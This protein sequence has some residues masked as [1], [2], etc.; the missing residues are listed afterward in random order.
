MTSSALS[1]LYKFLQPSLDT[2]VIPDSVTSNSGAATSSPFDTIKAQLGVER[3]V[4]M[5]TYDSVDRGKSIGTFGLGGCTAGF[6]INSDKTIC[7][8]YDPLELETELETLSKRHISEKT[9][10][11]HLVIKEKEYY[12]RSIDGKWDVD[13]SVPSKMSKFIAALHKFNIPHEI[14]WYSQESDA[15]INEREFVCVL[16]RSNCLQ[17]R[18]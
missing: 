7:F 5:S 1:E 11:V 17:L 18:R 12:M 10:K 3:V 8:H 14:S 16:P 2:I 6:I 13:R 4:D 9:V 15:V